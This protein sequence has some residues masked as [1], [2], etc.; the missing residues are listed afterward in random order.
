MNEKRIIE[1]QFNEV[2]ENELDNLGLNQIPKCCGKDMH[3]ETNVPNMLNPDSDCDFWICWDC[4]RF[5]S[6]TDEQLDE[7]ELE[8]YKDNYQRW[9]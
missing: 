6:L 8:N 9:L 4:G 2:I 3:H 7:E 1:N 5:I